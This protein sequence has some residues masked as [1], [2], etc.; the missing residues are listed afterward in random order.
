M[1]ELTE[2]ERD[3]IEAVANQCDKARCNCGDPTTASSFADSAAVLRRLL[4]RD[5][6]SRG[7]VAV[8]WENLYYLKWS[9]AREANELRGMLRRNPNLD[10]FKTNIAIE[11]LSAAIA[12]AEAALNTKEGE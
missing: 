12:E 6:A 10:P 4:A 1:I 5:A 3:V 11:N 2:A 7:K 9:A 8:S